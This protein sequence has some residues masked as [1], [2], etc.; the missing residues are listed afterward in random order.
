[1]AS[2]EPAGHHA[3]PVPAHVRLRPPGS[4]WLCV[5]LYGPQPFEDQVIAGPLR[6]FG[7]F[8]LNAG[9]ADGWHFLRYTDPDPHLRVRFHGQPR[10]LLGPLLRQVCDWAGELVADGVRTRLA[11]DTYEREVER[12]GGDEGMRAAE[13]VFTADSPAAAEI[14]DLSR[15]EGSPYD[16]T[17]LI[18]LSMDNLL[19]D[20]G[21]STEERALIYGKAAAL[22]T[23]GGQEHRRRKDDLRPLLGQPGALARTPEGRALAALLDGRH[24]ALADTA[25]YLRALEDDDRLGHPRTVL[26]RSYLHLHANRLLGTNPSQERLALELL[27]RT[28]EGLMRAPVN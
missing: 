27:R 3:H 25:E 20:L 23:E 28:H 9:L 14:L 5:K 6:T 17:T 16:L 12:Y 22:S 11:F 8:V 18:V 21:M 15:Q 7:E 24:H 1:M 2:A 4:D 10:T 19:R 26:C 13:A